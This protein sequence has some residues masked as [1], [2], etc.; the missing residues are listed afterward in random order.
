MIL[1]P[2]PIECLNIYTNINVNNNTAS[3]IDYYFVVVMVD[4]ALFDTV[5]VVEM[6]AATMMTNC[7]DILNYHQPIVQHSV[8]QR[9]RTMVHCTDHLRWPI[10][11]YMAIVLTVFD[12]VVAVVT[13]GAAYDKMIVNMAIVIVIVMK[14]MAM[15]MMMKWAKQHMG[16]NLKSYMAVLQ[17]LVRML[18]VIEVLVAVMVVSFLAN[19]PHVVEH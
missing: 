12:T 13:G 8:G 5:G 11:S 18:F 15:R 9:Y 2:I 10:A 19:K 14:M 6:V 16:N 17:R 4:F 3:S 7:I 1:L